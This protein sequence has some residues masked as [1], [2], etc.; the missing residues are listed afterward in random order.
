MSPPRG[1]GFEVVRFQE[2]PVLRRGSRWH[3]RSSTVEY[4]HLRRATCPASD[5]SSLSN[6][7]QQTALER[8]LRSYTTAS[9]ADAVTTTACGP[10]ELDLFP[11]INY[12]LTRAV[13]PGSCSPTRD[14]KRFPT[15]VRPF[16]QHCSTRWRVRL[17]TYQW[18]DTRR[19]SGSTSIL[20]EDW[21]GS[22]MAFVLDQRQSL[23]SATRRLF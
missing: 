22:R 5:T 13:M 6:H 4:K 23:S 20:F 14:G 3:T 1:H 15:N 2:S 19:A 10:L 9:R 18:S 7:Q 21:Y 17:R 16:N 8:S 11:S 12:T